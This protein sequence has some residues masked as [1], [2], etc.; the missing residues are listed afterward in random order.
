MN[1]VKQ[2]A[3]SSA[4]STKFLIALLPIIALSALSCKTTKTATTTQLKVDSLANR[5]ITT[6]IANRTATLDRTITLD[7]LELTVRQILFSPPDSQGRVVPTT[8]TVKHLTTGSRKKSD[9]TTTAADTASL[10]LSEHT[11]LD[12]HTTE[13]TKTK[14]RNDTPIAI[15]VISLFFLTAILLLIRN[16]LHR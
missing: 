2:P 4:P 1:C 13:K 8:Y 3:H 11:D 5:Q 14:N 16:L 15:A 9:I 10:S 12:K 7:S 6:G